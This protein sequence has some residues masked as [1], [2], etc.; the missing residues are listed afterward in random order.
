LVISNRNSFR[1]SFDKIASVYS[2]WKSIWPINILAL[3]MASPP[4]NRYCANRIVSAHFRYLFKKQSNATA[5][6]SFCHKHLLLVTWPATR[7][8]ALIGL[9]VEYVMRTDRGQGNHAADD[10]MTLKYPA[11]ITW[12][13]LSIRKCKY[14]CSYISPF[15]HLFLNER[16]C[17]HI[18][19]SN[20]L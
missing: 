9:S 13:L 6:D 12:P 14:L 19:W 1:V 17:P 3:E 11:V 20:V 15:K 18:F 5:G 8:S 7:L 16:S 10:M 4:G 2:I